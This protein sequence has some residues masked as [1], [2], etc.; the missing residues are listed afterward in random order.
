MSLPM[1]TIY[2]RPLDYPAGYVVRR[3]H[4]LPE[5][6]MQADL[7]AQYAGTLEEARATIPPGLV[8]L[9]RAPADDPSILEVWL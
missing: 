1:W 2:E 9:G 6:Q 3:W 7:A 4:V 5:G 8:R